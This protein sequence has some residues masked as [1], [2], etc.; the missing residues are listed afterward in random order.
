MICGTY[1]GVPV[2][3]FEIKGH[4]VDVVHKDGKGIRAGINMKT[5]DIVVLAPPGISYHQ[6]ALEAVAALEAGRFR[7]KEE[8]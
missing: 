3:E 1:N 7:Y 5:G 4:T 8:A 6:A 2:H